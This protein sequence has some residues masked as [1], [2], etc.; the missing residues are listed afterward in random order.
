MEDE[1]NINEVKRKR[2][3]L[4]REV[5]DYF[6]T[7]VRHEVSSQIDEEISFGFF[8]Q[9]RIKSNRSNQ[10]QSDFDIDLSIDHKSKKVCDTLQDYIM[11]MAKNTNQSFEDDM[12]GI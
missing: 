2:E 7:L 8:D 5:N 12:Q 9:N 4:K 6:Q 11:E 10:V 1:L 3:R